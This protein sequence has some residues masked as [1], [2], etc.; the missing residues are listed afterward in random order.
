MRDLKIESLI[1]DSLGKV[2]FDSTDEERFQNQTLRPILKFQ[3]DLLI[4]VMKNYIKKHKTDFNTFSI[5]KKLIFFENSIQKDIKLRNALKGMIIGLFQTSE[6]ESYIQNS[7]ALNK[8]MM[9]LLIE[10][11]K[12]Q[13]QLFE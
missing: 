10:R 4:L 2:F 5:P 11:Y 3:N 13:V 1:E 9:H 6:Y 8:R 7:S 12:S